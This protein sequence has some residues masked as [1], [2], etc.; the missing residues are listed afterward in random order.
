MLALMAALA[1][2][3]AE[4]YQP[5]DGE[6]LPEVQAAFALLDLGELQQGMEALRKAALRHPL[7]PPPPV[8]AGLQL[9]NKGK[10]VEGRRMLEQAAQVLDGHPDVALTLGFVAAKEGRYADAALQYKTA[11]EDAASERW[12]AEQRKQFLSIAHWGA[13]QVA[14]RQGKWKRARASLVYLR[15][16]VRPNDPGVLYKLGAA[17]FLDGE[18]GK[19]EDLLRLATRGDPNLPPAETM[20]GTLWM[21][22]AGPG[23]QAKAD[24]LLAAGAKEFPKNPLA[25]RAWLERLLGKGEAAEA[26]A[27]ARAA[28]KELPDN[29][30]M[31]IALLLALRQAGEAAAAAQMGRQWLAATPRDATQSPLEGGRPLWP[32]YANQTALALAEA[33]DEGERR[34][35][36]ELA[37][38]ARPGLLPADALATLGL[39]RLRLG[40]RDEA[41]KILKQALA[42]GAAAADVP[43]YYALALKEKGDVA[44]AVR[45]L[46]RALSSAAQF[47]HRGR[48]AALRKELQPAALPPA[49]PAP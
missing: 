35:A 25:Q 3:G 27:V 5:F 8:V 10:L 48:A 26:V 4:D 14:E 9:M 32:I 43:Y 22:T 15:E 40:Q 12:T 18:T 20:L 42:T 1:L 2:A 16:N 44:E 45:Q 28:L 41:E 34:Q 30:D 46:D 39:C 38:S 7:L 24:A 37:E 21:K 31:R 47:V 6:R 49:A 19:G 11:I 23:N 17:T 13:A 36:L 33:A 29:V